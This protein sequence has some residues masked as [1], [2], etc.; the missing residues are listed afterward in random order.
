MMDRKIIR[1]KNKLIK[2][3]GK[4]HTEK[5]HLEQLVSEYIDFSFSIDWMPGD[6]FIILNN[7]TNTV[8]P[9]DTCILTIDKFGTLTEDQ[10]D[11]I[12]I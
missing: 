7:D 5:E 8:A 2:T 10:H 9:L 12:G 6:G 11:L 3:E 4:Y 1:Q